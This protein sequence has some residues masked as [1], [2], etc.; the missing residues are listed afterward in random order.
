VTASVVGAIGPM[1][2]QAEIERAKRKPT[3]SLD[4]YDYYL[5]GLAHVH[6][7]SRQASDEALQLFYRAIELDPNF[8]AAYGM[9]A[10]CF[11]MRKAARWVNNRA[12]EIAE[13]E[14]LARRAATLGRSDATALCTAGLALGFVVGDLDDGV[15]LTDRAIVLNPNLAWAWLFSAWLQVRL[16]E[17]DIA[18][19]RFARAMRLSP[20][21]PQ[22][23][24]MHTGNAAAHFFAGRYAE[25]LSS[26]ETAVRQQP[27]YA[28]AISI[29]AASGALAGRLSEAKKAAARLRELDP[30]LRIP[31][32]MDLIPFRQP[33][34]ARWAEGLRKAGLPE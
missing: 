30:T 29:A 20:H 34:L 27:N 3:E 22:F 9:A 6:Q 7:W 1:L 4:A 15:A 28:L 2:E 16:G 17:P 19:E 13:A 23:F 24:N 18:I 33:V 12:Q 8:A 32:L 14:R 31:D 5:R 10:R 11:S 21:D 25:A 26:A